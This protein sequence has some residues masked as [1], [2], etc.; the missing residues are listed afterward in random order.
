MKKR[1]IVYLILGSKEPVHLEV[2]ACEEE[3]NKLISLLET[4]YH[5]EY[6]SILPLKDV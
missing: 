2:I 5:F 6:F 4:T 1:R 3:V